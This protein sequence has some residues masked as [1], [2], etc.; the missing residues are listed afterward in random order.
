VDLFED[1]YKL[2]FKDVFAY[3]QGLSNDKFIAEEITEETFYKALKN[4][5]RFK[6]SCDIRV[7]LCQ[8]AKNSYYSYCRKH[9]RVT[10][11]PPLETL[12]KDCFIE[13]KF[14]EEET[15]LRI[16]CFLHDMKEPYKEVFSLRV[17]GELS[18]AQIGKVFGKTESWARVTY[19]RAKGKIIE[20][21]EEKN[22]E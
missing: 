14:I 6:G 11:N 3:A 17:F 1:V 5:S 7:W 18:F 12:V 13:N 8:I 4:L 22:H 9:K 16:H 2:Y 19:H 15:A 21:M 20:F 10:D